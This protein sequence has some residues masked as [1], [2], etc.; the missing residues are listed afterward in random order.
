MARGDPASP[1]TI[2]AIRT[3]A[4]AGVCALD[5][6]VALGLSSGGVQM[7]ARRNGIKLER[8]GARGMADDAAAALRMLDSGVEMRLIGRI[9]G[10]SYGW[11]LA[12]KKRTR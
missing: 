2:D 6:A 8:S 4:R 3:M 12:L 11:V 9:V 7:I 10:R 1:A 5:V